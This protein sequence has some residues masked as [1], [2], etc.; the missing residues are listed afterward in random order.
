MIGF[1]GLRIHLST[2]AKNQLPVVFRIPR[3]WMQHHR[4]VQYLGAQPLVQE[5]R[6]IRMLV[7]LAVVPVVLNQ[8]AIVSIS[9]YKHV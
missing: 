9:I 7:D 5:Q 1:F 3:V 6:V 2:A 8:R 4:T